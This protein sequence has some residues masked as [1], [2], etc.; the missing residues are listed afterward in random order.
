M[1]ESW[2]RLTAVSIFFI[3]LQKTKLKVNMIAT[4]VVLT[5]VLILAILII[6]FA[7][8]MV[9]DKLELERNPINKKFEVLVGIIND[10]GVSK[11]PI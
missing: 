8:Q 1:A 5:I 3:T 6:P 10:E 4:I 2:I 11:H 7:R 9:K